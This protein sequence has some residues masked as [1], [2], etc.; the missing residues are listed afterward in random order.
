MNLATGVVAVLAATGHSSSYLILPFLGTIREDEPGPE[1]QLLDENGRKVFLAII[2]LKEHGTLIRQSDI[3]HE[4]GIG[5]RTLAT[6]R[7]NNSMLASLIDSA[8]LFCLD[9]HILKTSRRLETEGGPVNYA[10][11]AL[12]AEIAVETLRR[13]RETNKELHRTL[14]YIISSTHPSDLKI[15]SAIETLKKQ[16]GPFSYADIVREAN[17][18]RTTL[19]TRMYANPRLRD[20]INSIVLSTDSRILR[21]ID[22]LIAEGTGIDQKT[23]AE[24]AGL[25]P[26]TVTNRKNNNAL[27]KA[28]LERSIRSTDDRILATIEK[29]KARN[30]EITQ[31]LIAV[32]SGVSAGTVARRK[33]QSPLIQEAVNDAVSNCIYRMIATVIRQ[34]SEEGAQVTQQLIAQRLD[35]SEA[36]IVYHK[37]H[38]NDIY[39]LIETALP[40][41]SINRIRQAKEEL[42][43]ED[44]PCT[45]R[46]LALRAGV[47]VAT[48]SKILAKNPDMAAEVIA[49]RPRGII[50]ASIEACKDA[51]SKRIRIYGNEI[52]NTISALRQPALRGGNPSLLRACRRLGIPL[53]VPKNDRVRRVLSGMTVLP[54]YSPLS[55]YLEQITAT[56][57][58]MEQEAVQ[59]WERIQQ[60]DKDA[61]DELLTRTRPLV[62]FVI[63][64]NLHERMDPFGFKEELLWHL[65]T[66]GDLILASSWP[67]WNRQGRFLWFLLRRLQ[68]GL[69]SARH[70][71]FKQRQQQ[72]RQE[73]SISEPFTEEGSGNFTMEQSRTMSAHNIPPD[74]I[75]GILTENSTFGEEELVAQRD[76]ESGIPMISGYNK[77][78]LASSLPSIFTKLGLSRALESG[79][80]NKWAVFMTGSLGRMGTAVTGNCS[81][82]ALVLT[83]T[84][85]SFLHQSIRTLAEELSAVPSETP[86]GQVI[87]VIGKDAEYDR[88][89]KLINGTDSKWNNLR[90]FV[91]S[92]QR[93]GTGLTQEE[94]I[95]NIVFVPVECEASDNILFELLKNGILC[96][97]SEANARLTLTR[98]ILQHLSNRS[99]EDAGRALLD[100]QISFL[101]DQRA[102]LERIKRKKLNHK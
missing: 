85:A 39:E 18:D 21:A 89:M 49:L 76:A 61:Q 11:I 34:L 72:T 91:M 30:V 36:S 65:I 28:A 102:H 68:D 60:G 53:P 55:R 94:G 3:A 97:E 2:R 19:R 58:L 64:N 9:Q 62:K 38:N 16:S 41:S 88:V 78:E 43:L 69:A 5:E 13:R 98:N 1:S 14:E 29:L 40:L 37:E 42:F 24:R 63:E 46:N 52:C 70:D 74:E 82:K 26:A 35:I 84:T 66:E 6:Y 4:A 80:G 95:A 54:E 67:A 15:I 90:H 31:V 48:V 96:A 33:E 22:E 87:L 44:I 57:A 86:S 20:T 56:A 7:A 79:L 8:I 32:E 25:D 77:Q 81:F 51:L 27:I 50:F 99:P 17:V 10:R 23:I 71:F 47:S 73:V 59:L 83:D 93:F 92:L 12:E 45:Q 101:R 75:L 100:A